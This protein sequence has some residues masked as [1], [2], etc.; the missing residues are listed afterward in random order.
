MNVGRGDLSGS[1]T[2][3]QRAIALGKFWVM[4]MEADTKKVLEGVVQV[5]HTQILWYMGSN[6]TSWAGALAPSNL[7][8]GRKDT[9]QQTM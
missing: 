8:E 6:L 1:S 5:G 3:V 9:H 2:K 7:V 4:M